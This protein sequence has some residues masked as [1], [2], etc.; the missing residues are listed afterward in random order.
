MHMELERIFE[1]YVTSDRD[2]LELIFKHLIDDNYH[3]CK[4]LYVK[5]Y[6][7]EL[8][9]YDDFDIF[10][11]FWN[12]LMNKER[13]ELVKYVYHNFPGFRDYVDDV[14]EQRYRNGTPYGSY[15]NV[16]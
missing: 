10:R 7:E 6:W 13:E 8:Y 11:M 15:R 4:G 9:D 1:Q 5:R 12:Y 3:T 16:Y 2:N 14:Y